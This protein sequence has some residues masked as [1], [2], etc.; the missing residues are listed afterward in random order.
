MT[1]TN[2]IATP[3]AI[4]A[5]V[6][7]LRGELARCDTKASIVLAV[8][9]AVLAGIASKALDGDLH[10][11]VPAAIAGALG[12]AVLVTATVLLLLAISPSLKGGGFPSWTRLSIPEVAERIAAG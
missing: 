9:L 6:N 4:D 11:S 3:Q 12:T 1:T 2:P 10:L 5:T 7:G 8:P